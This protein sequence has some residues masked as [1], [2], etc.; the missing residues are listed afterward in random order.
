MGNN[1]HQPSLA[2]ALYQPGFSDEITKLE[3]EQSEKLK[4]LLFQQEEQK[5]AEDE[6][7]SKLRENIAVQERHLEE[8]RAQKNK[9]IE[10]TFKKAEETE[11]M[12]LKVE[13]MD[14]IE[15]IEQQLQEKMKEIELSKE[16]EEK[17]FL[18]LKAKIEE[19]RS[20]KR[21]EAVL[22]I[23]R[24]YRGYRARKMYGK[25]LLELRIIRKQKEQKKL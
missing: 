22:T 19:E 8:K 16:K 20:K 25:S 11:N 7:L 10:M 21:L 14:I 15:E 18:K 5:K 3:E 17:E 23:Q 4:E 2:V 1:H 13:D 9:E 12:L 24:L 6:T